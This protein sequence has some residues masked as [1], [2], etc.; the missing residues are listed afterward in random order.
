MARR[1][2]EA[3]FY[4]PSPPGSTTVVASPL[5]PMVGEP[6]N[7]DHPAPRYENNR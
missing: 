4:V 1:G 7:G 3:V 5:A 6:M 2:S